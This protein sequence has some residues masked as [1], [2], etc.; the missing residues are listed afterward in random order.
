M[1]SR[2]ATVGAPVVP[3]GL[4]PSDRETQRW[5][6]PVLLVVIALTTSA[7]VYL[8]ALGLGKTNT[9]TGA[10]MLLMP[11]M[12]NWGAVD[13]ALVF[14]MWAVMMVAM[15]LPSAWPMVRTFARV[16]PRIEPNG[17]AVGYARIG[18]FVGA[19][20]LVWAG[21]SAAI[22]LLQWMLLEVG[23]V[24]P[25][26]V[27]RSPVVAGALLVAV[28]LYQLTPLK[29]ACL[30]GCRSPLAFLM[31]AWRPGV[32]GAWR[33]GLR[34]GVLCIG[35]CWLLMALLLVLGVMNLAWVAVLTVFILLEKT[36]PRA[37]W[38]TP[39]SGIALV[40]W[41]VALAVRAAT[42]V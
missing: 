11:R 6:T 15:M 22:T 27:L 1:D 40:V 16:T 21:F 3:A 31:T 19:Y 35:C 38:I 2:N 41:G 5:R 18:A 10:A 7:W 14:A 4:G 33:M 17:D 8:L 28:G 36:V 37:R 29:R 42:V 26:M 13:A 39:A 9:G 24:T 25:M 23:W 32:A 12:T 30:N 34:H 20:L